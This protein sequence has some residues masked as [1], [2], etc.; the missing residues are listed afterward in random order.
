MERLMANQP[1]P[2]PLNVLNLSSNKDLIRRLIYEA[3]RGFVKPGG[4][5]DLP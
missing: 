5:V 4:L 2:G 1:T 3:G